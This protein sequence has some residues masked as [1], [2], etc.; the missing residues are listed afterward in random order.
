MKQG[1]KT[2]TTAKLPPLQ[3]LRIII[4]AGTF[5]AQF[6]EIQLGFRQIYKAFALLLKLKYQTRIFNL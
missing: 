5:R 1:V 6:T 4:N 3:A 2:S